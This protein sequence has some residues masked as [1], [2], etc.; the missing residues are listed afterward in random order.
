MNKIILSDADIDKGLKNGSMVQSGVQIRDT[1]SGQI[2]KVIHKENEMSVRI[3]YT[4][5]Q[6]NNNYIYKADLKPIIKSILLNR[7]N[8]TYDELEEAY[9]LVTDYFNIYNTYKKDIDKLFYTCLEASN[10]FDIKIKNEIN[11][12]DVS[13]IKIEDVG[14]LK[15]FSSAYVDILFTYIISTYTYNKDKFSKDTVILDKLLSFESNVKNLYEQLL[16]SSKRETSIEGKTVTTF[17]MQNSVYSKYIFDDSYNIY[18]VELLVRHDSRFE[19]ITDIFSFY[20]KHFKKGNFRNSNHNYNYNNTNNEV[21]ISILAN[22]TNAD[23]NREGLIE[24]LY[25]IL[26]AI[27]NLKNVRNEVIS[28]DDELSLELFDK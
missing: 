3:P 22:L 19:S 12:L 7:Q 18:D 6:V 13:K 23:D 27:E 4:L 26:E 11:N 28:L 2:V 20:K 25:S 14:R 9:C 21:K 16:V 15:K 17:D 24:V 10:K 1:K 8:D 5:I